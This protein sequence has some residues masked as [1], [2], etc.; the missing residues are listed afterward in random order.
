MENHTGAVHVDI[1]GIHSLLPEDA[2]NAEK[3]G[4][5]RNVSLM[6]VDAMHGVRTLIGMMVSM[7]SF[8][9]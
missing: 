7:R 9:H 6:Q 1:D 8:K 5:T 3:F 4:K 2:H